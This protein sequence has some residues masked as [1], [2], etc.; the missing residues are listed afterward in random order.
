MPQVDVN[1][2]GRR[3]QIACDE[4]QEE[5]LSQLA[6][7]VDKRVQELVGAIGQVGDARLL[8]MTSLLVADELSE[9]C[10][11]LEENIDAGNGGGPG[12]PG[13]VA[14]HEREEAMASMLEAAA[15]RIETLAAGVEQT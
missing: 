14:A 7:Y 11:A 10:S 4:G 2:N 3:Y 1:I 5:H 15:A 9:A 6:E 12:G 13:G 8:V